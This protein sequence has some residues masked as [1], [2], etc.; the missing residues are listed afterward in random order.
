MARWPA[1]RADEMRLVQ[2][3]EQMPIGGIVLIK[4]R[5]AASVEGVLRRVNIGNNGGQ[6]G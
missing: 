6:G 5:N 4:L 3:S 2:I 1:N